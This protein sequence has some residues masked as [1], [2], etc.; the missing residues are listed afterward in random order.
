[1]RR[2]IL[3]LGGLLV[4]AALAV[5]GALRVPAVQD[6]VMR[7]VLDRMVSARNDWLFADDALRALVC[8]SGSPLAHPTRAKACVAVFAAGRFW[9]VDTGSGSWNRLSLL[10]VD[11]TRI[12]GVMF[13]HF[14][15]DHIGD[16]GELNMNTWVQG[17]KAPLR[18]FGPPGV[19]R[20]VAGYAEA[21]ELDTGYRVLHHGSDFNKP[22]LS[23]YVTTV[24]AEPAE[25][26]ATTV[27]VDED[28]LRISAF[29]VLHD[30]IKPAY[31][32]RFDYK[33]RSVVVS[34]DTAKSESLIAAAKGADALF[35]EAQANHIVALVGEAAGKAGLARAVKIMQDI[36]SYHTT[37]EQAA[38]VAN[39]AGA[40]LL[41]FYHLT[42]SPQNGLMETVFTRG[43]SAVRPDGWLL[44]DDG[45]LVELPVGSDAVKVSRLR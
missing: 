27:F 38:E 10:R 37:P 30:P 43:V 12:G 44:A 23:G 29:P 17:R 19:E 4:L 14:H 3:W 22:E 21:Y 13:T 32:Y 7:A 8:G 45:A 36:P 40:K 28:G 39:A 20:V 15:S 25:T 2:A 9:V 31:G 35:H 34:G 42:P 24:V 6:R 18:V 11:P 1:M 41:V 33:G 16:L 5:A 26:G